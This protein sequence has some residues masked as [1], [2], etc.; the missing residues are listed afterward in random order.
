MVNDFTKSQISLVIA[1]ASYTSM[2]Y[3]YYMAKLS[4][5][6][7]LSWAGSHYIGLSFSPIVLIVIQLAVGTITSLLYFYFIEE[8]KKD[9]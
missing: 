2:V 5:V 7:D 3:S 9:G 6:G 1:I 8:V 4:S